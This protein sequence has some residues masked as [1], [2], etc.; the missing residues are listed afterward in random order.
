MGQPK[1]QRVLVHGRN[2]KQSNWTLRQSMCF[3]RSLSA[4]V[5]VLSSKVSGV[6]IGMEV[7]TSQW[8]QYLRI[9]SN[10]L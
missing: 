2:R 3:Y 8:L 6:R 5:C 4:C 9:K 1:K 7:G 10:L